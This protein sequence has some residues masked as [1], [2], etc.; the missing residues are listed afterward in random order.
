MTSTKE[1]TKTFRNFKRLRQ[2][3]TKIW[4][5]LK[6]VFS[7]AIQ[8][9][10]H[11]TR[12]TGKKVKQTQNPIKSSNGSGKSVSQCMK[13][14]SSSTRL[15]ILLHLFPSWHVHS[16]PRNFL[17]STTKIKSKIFSILR[18]SSKLKLRLLIIWNRKLTQYTKKCSKMIPWQTR[19]KP[20]RLQ[21]TSRINL[22]NWGP[23]KVSIF[24]HMLNHLW[25]VKVGTVQEESPILLSPNL[26]TKFL[27]SRSLTTNNLWN[28]RNSLK[29]TWNT[30]RK[31][32][33]TRKIHFWQRF[34]EFTKFQWEV[35]NTT[36]LLC[37]T[38]FSVSKT[39]QKFMT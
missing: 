27:L 10:W 16:I 6:L 19:L 5:S 34:T 21:F 37:R 1:E 11:S 36:A 8:L 33:W 32:N 17:Q 4:L 13:G 26:I 25:D 38:Y 18:Y 15:G 3:S 35:R 24:R 20:M 28:L 29:I 23:G 22:K 7:W 2:T 14:F 30:L 31:Q 39:L 9:I 12:E